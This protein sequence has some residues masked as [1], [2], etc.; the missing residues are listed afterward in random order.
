MVLD[1]GGGL[2]EH[3]AGAA[4]GASK[5]GVEGLDDFDDQTDD[6]GGGEEFAA[7]PA[8]RH[9]EFTEEIFVDFA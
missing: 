9:G 3:A 6:A 2:D 1:E 7:F 5:C 4:G 8:F